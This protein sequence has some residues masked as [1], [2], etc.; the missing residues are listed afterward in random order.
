MLLPRPILPRAC[1]A[2]P[3]H[4]WGRRLPVASVLIGSSRG[5][6]ISCSSSPLPSAWNPFVARFA[7]RPPAARQSAGMLPV[8]GG[9][10]GGSQLRLHGTDVQA[11]YPPFE[12]Q[13][14]V[15][16]TWAVT[17]RRDADGQLAD[18]GQ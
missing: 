11:P 14:C 10:R 1:L 16:G 7:P 6:N 17:P 13:R 3:V 9:P 18:F 2:L 15:V 12:D 8:S 5:T 4:T